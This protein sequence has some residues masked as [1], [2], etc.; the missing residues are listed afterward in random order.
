MNAR[1]IGNLNHSIRGYVLDKEDFQQRR[2]FRLLMQSV[3]PS[4]QL[5]RAGVKQ[6]IHDERF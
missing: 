4:Y 3:N 5:I 6:E 2:S 1:L